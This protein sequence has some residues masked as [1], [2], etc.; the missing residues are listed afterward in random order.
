MAR[1]NTPKLENL[2]NII[3]YFY[4]LKELP[5]TGWK[6]KLDIANAES[7]ASHTLLMIVLV[8]FFSDK[9]KNENFVQSG[10]YYTCGIFSRENIPRCS[11][12]FDIIFC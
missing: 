11:R 6:Q 10:R 2:S 12:P 8:F 4:R 5:R 7:V 3:E 1:A 9:K